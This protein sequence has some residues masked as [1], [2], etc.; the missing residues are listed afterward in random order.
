MLRPVSIRRLHTS[1][2]F[3]RSGRKQIYYHANTTENG[4]LK[5]DGFKTAVGDDFRDYNDRVKY[6]NKRVQETGM[7]LLRGGSVKQKKIVQPKILDATETI[8]FTGV[9]QLS[10]QTIIETVK[11]VETEFKEKIGSGSGGS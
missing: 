8:S 7:G 1:R 4:Q 5:V 10:Q 6:L 11:Q 9:P 3:Y 2:N